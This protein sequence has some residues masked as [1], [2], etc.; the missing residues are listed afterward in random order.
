MNLVTLKFPLRIA[1]RCDEIVTVVV[2][3][4]GCD[5]GEVNSDASGSDMIATKSS[6][7]YI[8]LWLNI[9]FRG[10]LCASS[11]LYIVQSVAPRPCIN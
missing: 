3:Y 5:D 2:V 6:S 11:W 10:L 4:D 9:G 8:A 7:P 1:I